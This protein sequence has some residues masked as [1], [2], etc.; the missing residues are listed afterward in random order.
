LLG[1]GKENYPVHYQK[2]SRQVG[3][4]PRSEERSPHNLYIE[5]LAEQGL[6]GFSFF[7]LILWVSFK[8]IIRSREQFFD[9]GDTRF[10]GL[11]TAFGIGFFGYLAASMFIHSSYPRFLWLL[12]GI[13]LA[14]P[15]LTEI[16]LAE[17][18]KKK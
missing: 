18:E 15:R 9:K 16:E 6:L 12:I 14:L 13:A 3:L 4:D 1:V 8:N 5:V 11:I 17:I 2:Y 10:T 7:M